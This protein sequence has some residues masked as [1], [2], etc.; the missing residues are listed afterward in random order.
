MCLIG[1]APEGTDK[2]SEKFINAIIIASKTNTDGM[3]FSFK[4]NSTKK[5]YISKGY[6]T[7][8][9]MIRSLK[10][11]RL[12]KEDELM[13]HLRIGNRGSKNTDMCHPFILSNIEEEILQNDK[14]VD[15]PT[16]M[17][18]G[19]FHSYP[20]YNINN[21]SDTYLFIKDFMFNKRIIDFVKEDLELFKKVFSEKLGTNKL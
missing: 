16:M 10:S 21:F 3:G 6:N 17:H 14:Y 8:E 7:V 19:T 2:Y 20:S 12:K 11:K 9:G 1:L 18:N 4:K 15:K 5:V 13:I